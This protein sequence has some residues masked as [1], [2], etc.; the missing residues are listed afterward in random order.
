MSEMTGNV[1]PLSV[2][3]RGMWFA[4]RFSHSNAVFNV[5]ELVEIHGSVDAALFETALRQ[6]AMEAETVRLRFVEVADDLHQV[7]HPA[8]EG[9]LPFMD[10]SAETDPRGAAERWARAEFTAPH[11]PMHDRLWASALI[12]AAPDRFFWYHRSHHILMDGFGGG[13]FARRLADVYS[14]LVEGRP[15]GDTP[16]GPLSDLIEEDHAYRQSERFVRDRN[17]WMAR[18]S[19]CPEPVTLATRHAPNEGGLLRQTC[20]LPADVVDAMRAFAQRAGSSLP[21]LMI[22]ATVV[23]VHRMTGVEDLTLGLPV[24]ARVSA[25]LRQIPG[26]VANVVP[27]RIAL[28]PDMPVHEVM[29]QVRRTVREALRHQSYR[30]EDLRHDLHWLAEQKHLLSTLINIEPLAHHPH[31]CRTAGDP[32]PRLGAQ[33]DTGR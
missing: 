25:R 33:Y 21:Q 20:Q 7:V 31:L 9:I 23:Y 27:L 22:A 26:M 17:Y 15:P 16:F 13:L 19:D 24:T 5:A 4:Q 18:F 3:Q 30:Y 1:F 29:R 28:H 11:D 2:A 14:A 10:L 32:R 8:V 6:T 12:K